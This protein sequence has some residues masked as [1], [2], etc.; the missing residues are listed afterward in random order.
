MKQRLWMCLHVFQQSLWHCLRA[1]SQRSY[2]PW[3][4]QVGLRTG[5][6]TG[7]CCHI[8]RSITTGVPQGSVLG[9][10]LF[11]VVMGDLDEG[12]EAKANR[13]RFNKA[14]GPAVGSL[15]PHTALQAWGR[16]AG[17]TLSRKG[18]ASAGRQWLNVSWV[19]PHHTRTPV[20]SW[21]GSILATGDAT[22][23]ILRSVL[24]P[25]L[26]ERY[27]GPEA[28]PEKS[29]GREKGLESQS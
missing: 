2:S 20:A 28:C 22:P 21:F 17:K 23:Q 9:P 10:V 19:C 5:C 11:N 26:Q 13:V 27:W 18:P 12:I 3:L 1:L 29:K 8:H 15:Q 16:V 6:V 24:D 4:G 14:M 7:E 25:V